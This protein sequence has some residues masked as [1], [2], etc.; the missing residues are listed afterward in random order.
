M[1]TP[2]LALVDS[3]ANAL[4]RRAL[5]CIDQ[6]N[7]ADG[8]RALPVNV[9]ACDKMLVLCGDT[10]AQRLWCIW[11]I[12]TLLAFTEVNAA[13]ERLLVVP[14]A[15]DACEQLTEFQLNTAHCY[16]P[17]EEAKLRLAIG[18]LGNDVFTERVR[19]LSQAAVAKVSKSTP[20][21]AP[22]TVER[23]SHCKGHSSEG[24]SGSSDAGLPGTRSDG[25]DSKQSDVALTHVRVIGQRYTSDEH[26][27]ARPVRASSSQGPFDNVLPGMAT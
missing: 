4:E 24:S 9:M 8:L 1:C 16:D 19:M 20:W 10:Y 25:G 22:K 26:E 21:T 13:L 12:F 15:N 2:R 27:E 11:E 23:S 7:I 5:A 6:K 14:L 17:N 3:S 18:S